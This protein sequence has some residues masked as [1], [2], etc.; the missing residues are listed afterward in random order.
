MVSAP[1]RAW[2]FSYPIPSRSVGVHLKPWGLAAFLPMSAGELRDRP[3]TIEKVWGRPAIAELRG[4][5]GAVDEPHQMLTLL[6]EELLRRMRQPHG[7]DLVRSVSTAIAA[8]RGTVAIGELIASEG[9]SSTYVAR[10]FRGDHRHHAE[11]AGSGA[12]L[13]DHRSS[14]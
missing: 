3:A 5:L 13:L 10:R 4:R 1:T 11:A 6:E 14:D 2:D 12:A 8:T 7:L 9:V